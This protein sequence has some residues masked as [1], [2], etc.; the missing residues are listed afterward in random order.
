M[1]REPRIKFTTKPDKQTEEFL[2]YDVNN[3]VIAHLLREV[4]LNTILRPYFLEL[5]NLEALNGRGKSALTKRLIRI[6][7]GQRSIYESYLTGLTKEL[8]H[9]TVRADSSGGMIPVA[10]KLHTARGFEEIVTN[11][12]GWAKLSKKTIAI[13]QRD[14]ALSFTYWK[15]TGRL[16]RA[17]KSDVT[18]QKR[19]LK[20]YSFMRVNNAVKALDGDRIYLDPTDLKAHFSL[21]VDVLTPK[22]AGKDGALMDTLITNPY[23][24]NTNSRT[25]L[26]HAAG[27][28]QKKRIQAQ[29]A[30]KVQEAEVQAKITALNKN[31]VMKGQERK[32]Y[33]QELVRKLIEVQGKQELTKYQFRQESMDKLTE[34]NVGLRRIILPEHQRPFI[35]KLS[36]YAGQVAL[37]DLK[38]MS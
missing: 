20:D 19:T 21:T 34:N 2:R 12:P 11:N 15:H 8:D 5:D 4:N 27:K 17:F 26:S 32:D 25:I 6:A 24:G 23:V 14:Q 29:E 13:K 3:K 10:V 22:W 9:P 33:R 35:R 16:A 7:K 31:R 37:K 38:T 1:A 28:M 30:L 36:K 18:A